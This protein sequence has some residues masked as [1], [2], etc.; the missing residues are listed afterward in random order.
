MTVADGESSGLVASPG[1][2]A[3]SSKPAN[4]GVILLAAPI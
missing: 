2:T 1:V 4:E 3:S